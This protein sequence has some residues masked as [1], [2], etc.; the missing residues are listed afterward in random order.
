MRAFI[1]NQHIPAPGRWSRRAWMAIVAVVAAGSSCA[2]AARA[3][4]LTVTTTGDPVG[5]SQCSLREAIA[6]IDAFGTPT[7]CGT[8]DS[9]G[10]TIVLGPHPYTLSIGPSGTDD[11]GTGDLD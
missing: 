11:N 7:V 9:S 6:A 3:A 4:T 10:N 5:N 2:S 8:A 1:G